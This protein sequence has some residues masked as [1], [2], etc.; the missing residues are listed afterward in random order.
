MPRLAVWFKQNKSIYNSYKHGLR[1]TYENIS[2]AMP[3][4][5]KEINPENAIVYIT[6][7]DKLPERVKLKI[8]LINYERHKKIHA[9]NYYLIRNLM[10]ALKQFYVVPPDKLELLPWFTFDKLNVNECFP[11][12]WKFKRQLTF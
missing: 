7:D 11:K 12:T 6:P 9:N 10:F 8:T 2:D 5:S 3:P 4:L 1:F